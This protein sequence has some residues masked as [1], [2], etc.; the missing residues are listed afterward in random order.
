MLLVI[1]GKPQAQ[2]RHR[3]T[4]S[5]NG[6]MWVYDP[7]ARDKVFTRQV[8]TAGIE[9]E[10]P[11]FE[12]PM[13]PDVYFR[14]YMPIPR[15]LSKARREH[16]EGEKLRHATKPDVDNMV[17][18]YLDVMKGVM[19]KDDNAV[20]LLGALKLYSPHPRVEIELTEGLVIEDVPET[21]CYAFPDCVICDE[22][23]ISPKDIPT[24]SESV[25]Y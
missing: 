15:S 12:F 4:R 14:F 23:Q 17:K 6:N 5:R 10:L 21:S 7:Q 1:P 11:N 25:H 13:F 8:M 16:A 2:K 9:R 24:F 18:Y 22:P 3:Y 19:I 20:K